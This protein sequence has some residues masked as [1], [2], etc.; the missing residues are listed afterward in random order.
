MVEY[1]LKDLGLIAQLSPEDDLVQRTT[2]LWVEPLAE[3]RPT[4]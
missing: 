4:R 2:I 1:A 3:V